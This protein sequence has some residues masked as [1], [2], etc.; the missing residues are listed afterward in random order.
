MLALAIGAQS[1]ILPLGHLGLGLG[2]GLSYT[3]VHGPALLPAGPALYSHGWAGAPHG[4]LIAHPG[5]GPLLAHGPAAIAAA[6]PVAHLGP[7]VA[8]HAGLVPG[9]TYVAKTRGAVHTAP[10]AGHLNSAASVNLLPAP[11][12]I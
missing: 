1:S 10:L 8:H 11:G 9:G 2:H 7:S 3:A 6:H 12:T 4:A 5:V